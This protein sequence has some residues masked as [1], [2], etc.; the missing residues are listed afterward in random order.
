MNQ[1]IIN[2]LGVVFAG[3]LAIVTAWYVTYRLENYK[4]DKKS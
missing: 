4:R 1:E 2:M 3:L